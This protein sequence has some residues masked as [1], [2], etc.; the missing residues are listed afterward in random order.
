MDGEHRQVVALLGLSHETVGGFSHCLQQSPAV[1]LPGVPGQHIQHPLPRE[2]FPLLIL[3][4]GKAVRIQEYRCPGRQ[5]TLLRHVPGVREHAHRQVRF[6]FQDLRRLTQQHRPVMT[7]VAILQP[8][9][10]KVQHTQEEGDEHRRLIALATG[11]VHGSENVRRIVQARGDHTEKRLHHRHHHGGRNA[12]ATHVTDDEKQFPVPDKIVVQVAA[13]LAGRFQGPVHIHVGPVGERRISLRQHLHLDFPGD[14]EFGSQPR[15]LDPGLGQPLLVPDIAEKDEQQD[16][17]ARKQQHGIEQAQLPGRGIHLVIVV[18]GDNL[19]ERSRRQGQD[20]DVG[21]LPFIPDAESNGIESLD[22]GTPDRRVIDKG[23]DPVHVCP[24]TML[25][26]RT[27][28]KPP[29]LR[30]RQQEG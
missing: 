24:H 19:P 13:H 5:L 23:D 3:G 17:K 7:G 9:G 6:R 27:C 12:F 30:E 8:A 11:F 4:F 1:F 2:Q 10:R 18:D 14:V 16:E 26:G 22:P 15:F 21:I 25:Q 20:M 29:F 28:H